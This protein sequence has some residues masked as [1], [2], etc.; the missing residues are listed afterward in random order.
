MD[1]SQWKISRG[2]VTFL[3]GC[4][5]LCFIAGLLLPANPP[6]A[7]AM[8]LKTRSDE[9]LMSLL[10]GE[11]ASEAGG[12][13]NINNEFVLNSL[14]ATNQSQFWLNTNAT[15]EVIDIWQTPYRIEL[16]GRTNFVVRSAGKDKIFGDADDIIFNSVS[17]DFVKP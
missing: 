1:K 7:K 14:F 5:L 16:V 15:G 6:R 2:F 10:L 9:R 8:I 4:F 3:L 13:T 11:R 17:N 12:L